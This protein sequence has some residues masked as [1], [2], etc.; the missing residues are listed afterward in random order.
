MRLELTNN[1]TKKVYTFDGLED[2][3]TSRIF[4]TLDIQLTETMDEGEYM[5]VLFDDDNIQKA[6]G[7]LQIGDYKPENKTYSAS[8]ENN[9]YI[10]YNG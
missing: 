10:Q 8:T 2:K 3:L 5:Y 9:G 1:V 7:L 4:Y 6:S